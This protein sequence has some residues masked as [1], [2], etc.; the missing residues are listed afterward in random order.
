VNDA[1]A[2]QQEKLKLTTNE[3]GGGEGGVLPAARDDTMAVA[4]EG[5]AGCSG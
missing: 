4:D 3:G 2:R 1:S 5:V